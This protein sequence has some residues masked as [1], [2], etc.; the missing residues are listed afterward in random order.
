MIS[1]KKLKKFQLGVSHFS[2]QILYK[3][4]ESK[5][6]TNKQNILREKK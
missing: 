1:D 2:S 6:Q 5:K 4:T 3:S